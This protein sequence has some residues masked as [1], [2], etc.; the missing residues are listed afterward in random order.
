[1]TNA[2]VEQIVSAVDGP[3]LT[4]KYRGGEK[5]IVV[6]ANTPIVAYVPSD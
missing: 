4:M 5:K 6:P 3:T 1:M 2:N